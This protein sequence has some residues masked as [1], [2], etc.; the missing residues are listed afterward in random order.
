[1]GS[2]R[3]WVS[4]RVGRLTAT[5]FMGLIGALILP[6][7]V[8]TAD[9]E[10]PP[11]APMTGLPSE[12][13]E[14]VARI[15][16]MADGTWLDLGKPAPDPKWGR[17]RGRSWGAKMSYAPD[18]RGAF[19]HGEGVHGWWNEETGRYMDDLWLYD[20]NAHRWVCVYP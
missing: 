1:M 5:A 9:A 15:K 7:S 13:G 16:A 19:L 12:P 8:A 6:S 2:A 10:N 11:A 14:H 4:V 20:A 18:L 3:A 17:A